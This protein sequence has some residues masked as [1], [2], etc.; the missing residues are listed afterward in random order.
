[1]KTKEI[2]CS[3]L[4]LFPLLANAQA[5]DR[6]FMGNQ[7]R[8]DYM[9]GKL[10]SGFYPIVKFDPSPIPKALLGKKQDGRDIEFAK[11]AEKFFEDDGQNLAMLMLDHGQIVYERYAEGVNQDSKM[12]SWSMAK[13]LT[14]YTVGE[15]LCSGKL[16]SLNDQAESYAPEIKDSAYGKATIKQLLTM[17]SGAPPGAPE[18]MGSQKDEWMNLTRGFKSI[19]DMINLYGARTENPDV[20]AYKNLD[21]DTLVL[22]VNGGGNFQDIFTKSIWNR[23]GPEKSATWLVDKDGVI[24]GSFGLGATLRDWARLALESLE[25]R[26]GARGK[27]IQ[28]FMRSATTKQIANEGG[29]TINY[30]HYGYQTWI[31][32]REQTGIYVW[33][34]AYGQKVMID[35]R[36][37]KILIL[38]RH[39]HDAHV[40]QQLSRLYRAWTNTPPFQSSASGLGQS[41][42]SK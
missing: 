37:K 8:S 33:L 41:N 30:Y 15:A 25:M 16:K 31:D 36:N 22:A 10:S 12:F 27:C 38:F 26:G 17:S 24:N 34:G 1:M 23:A 29:T 32:P 11:R 39:Q 40:N 14:A 5:S 42:T 2:L 18:Y 28:E 3:L 4:A 21:T 13:S 35:P 9:T 19:T 6:A 7:V 20:F